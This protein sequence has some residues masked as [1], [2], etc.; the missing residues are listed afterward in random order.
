M[1]TNL[2]KRL[3]VLEQRSRQRAGYLVVKRDSTGWVDEGG[4]HYSDD[5]LRADGRR[6][7]K[8]EY[9]AWPPDSDGDGGTCE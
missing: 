8:I 7:I 2:S 5:E 6:T 1:T 9:G 4:V 3:D